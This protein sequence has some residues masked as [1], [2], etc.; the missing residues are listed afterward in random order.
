MDLTKPVEDINAMIF[1]DLA[2]GFYVAQI[3]SRFFPDRVQ[4]HSFENGHSTATKKD[5]WAQI[6]RFC[7]KWQGASLPEDLVED[8]IN[9]KTNGAPD[10]GRGLTHGGCANHLLVSRAFLGRVCFFCNTCT[11]H[12]QEKRRAR[13]ADNTA[14]NSKPKNYALV[15]SKPVGTRAPSA[16]SAVEFGKAGKIQ[17][18]E[19][20]DVQ[21]LRRK[22]QGV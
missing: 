13:E 15:G 14:D 9:C 5:N 3:F 12:S 8:T 18:G 19:V 4:M 22:L 6:Q 16:K 20:S 2:N 7:R 1:K 21:E 11:H 17:L 10:N